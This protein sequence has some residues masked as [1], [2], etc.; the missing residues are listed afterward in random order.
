MKKI[1]NYYLK[2]PLKVLKLLWLPIAWFMLGIVTLVIL[3]ETEW[4]F[5]KDSLQYG[6]LDIS[7]NIEDFIN[8]EIHYFDNMA[9]GLCGIGYLIATAFIPSTIYNT[10]QMF[11]ANSDL[12]YAEYNLATTIFMLIFVYL[13]CYFAGRI[14][15]L[16]INYKTSDE[17]TYKIKKFANSYNALIFLFAIFPCFPCAGLAFILGMVNYKPLKVFVA[18][19]AQILIY[20]PLTYCFGWIVANNYSKRYLQP[21]LMIFIET[22]FNMTLIDWLALASILII[23]LVVLSLAMIYLIDKPIYK[24]Q[25]SFKN[26]Q[27]KENLINGEPK[28]GEE[29]PLETTKEKE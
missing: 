22:D 24:H 23:S 18:L 1:Y 3:Y 5:A 9:W 28:N 27:R 7:Q 16:W 2:N 25:H 13:F 10:L 11:Y 12:A 26:F 8:Y 17:V 14:Y 4:L 29:K 6:F 20:C 19:M 21:N 15:G